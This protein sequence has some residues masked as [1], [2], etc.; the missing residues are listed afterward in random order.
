MDPLVAKQKMEEQFNWKVLQKIEFPKVPFVLN[1][2]TAVDE[3]IEL[4]II[5]LETTGLNPTKDKAI[6]IA[7]IN[8][9]YNMTQ[10]NIVS[11]NEV[12][13]QFQDPNEE[14][15]D[16]IQ[17]FTGL[18][19]EQLVGQEF[20]IPAIKNFIQDKIL[21]SHNV[22]FDKSFLE[23]VIGTTKN[24]WLC[25]KD[26]VQW[27]TNYH[28]EAKKLEYIMFKL[29][30]WYETH[31]AVCDCFALVKL[32]QVLSEKG[33]VD[34]MLEQANGKFYNVYAYGSPFEIKDDL[35]NAGFR[36]NAKQKTW[37]KDGLTKEKVEKYLKIMVDL[38]PNALESCEVEEI[39]ATLRFETL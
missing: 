5:D 12:L 8:I 25:T 19:N 16:F 1:A 14:L 27:F 30:W 35:K 33:L 10:N 26:D 31:D 15:T 28:I 34:E 17:Q 13:E 11:V 3:L 38:Y 20:Q 23:Q 9:T 22:K 37:M 4:C 32:I 21:V 6:S 39:D 24:K 29:G 2:A 18:T 36:W 7:A